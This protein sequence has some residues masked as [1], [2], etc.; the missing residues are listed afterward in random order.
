MD[1]VHFRIQF[2]RDADWAQI[3]SSTTETHHRL[4]RLSYHIRTLLARAD[5]M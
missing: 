4:G 1:A 3:G 2:R 5:N